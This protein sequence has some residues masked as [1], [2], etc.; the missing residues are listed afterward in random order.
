MKGRTTF[1]FVTDG[2]VSALDR[3]K[4]AANGMDVRIGGGACHW[5]ARQDICC[6]SLM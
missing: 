1:H 3:A 5:I 2:I 6:A 4:A